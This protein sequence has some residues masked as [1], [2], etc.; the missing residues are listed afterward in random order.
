MIAWAWQTQ[1]SILLPLHDYD[2]DDR[3]NEFERI[4]YAFAPLDIEI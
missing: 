3:I 1:S 4:A 2:D